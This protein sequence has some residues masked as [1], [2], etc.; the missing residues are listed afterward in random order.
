MTK[1]EGANLRE[2]RLTDANLLV[3][4][5]VNAKIF[6]DSRNCDGSHHKS[7]KRSN[8][9][10][11]IESV[12]DVFEKYRELKNLSP[13]RKSYFRGERCNT[14][15]LRPSVMRHSQNEENS[16][17]ERESSMLLE[18]MIKTTI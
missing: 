5:L 7:R 8:Q 11:T 14:W 16:L 15:E 13:D 17:R 3:P 6:R 12:Q 4:S 1:L 9:Q 18:L 2:A 10:Q